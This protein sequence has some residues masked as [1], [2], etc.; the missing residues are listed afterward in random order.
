MHGMP[1]LH[2]RK[3]RRIYTA[4]VPTIATNIEVVSKSWAPHKMNILPQR[5]KE[6]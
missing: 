1:L 5:N 6:R 3:M 2:S 4:V